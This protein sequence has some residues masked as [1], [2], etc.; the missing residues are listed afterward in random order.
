MIGVWLFA[1]LC[2]C[3][4]AEKAS[5]IPACDDLYWQGEALSSP[6]EAAIFFH[7]YAGTTEELSIMDLPDLASA[8]RLCRVGEGLEIYRVGGRDLAGLG[9]LQTA[10]SLTL[11]G[12]TELET[13]A[14]AGSL[15]VISGTLVLEYLPALASLEGLSGLVAAGGLSV[16]QTG[17]QRLAWTAPTW[18][19]GR[20]DIGENAALEEVELPLLELGYLSVSEQI[21]T[22]VSLPALRTVD[23]VIIDAP[24]L[25]R[26]SAPALTGVGVRLHIAVDNPSGPAA[27]LD[28]PALQ[29]IPMF[30]VCGRISGTLPA[31]G[32]IGTLLQCFLSQDTSLQ[33]TLGLGDLSLPALERIGTIQLQEAEVSGWPEMPAIRAVEHLDLISVSGVPDLRWLAGVEAM[34]V[35]SLV[36][37]DTASLAGLERLAALDALVLYG[38]PD[39]TDAAALSGLAAVGAISIRTCPL[40]ARLELPLISRIDGD[41]TLSGTGLTDLEGFAGLTEIGGDLILTGNPELSAEEV[42]AFLGRVSVGGEVITE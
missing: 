38:L 30:D 21:L 14:G 26:L 31:L 29:S 40:L 32:A 13:L 7:D 41:L 23:T 24:R 25:D 22:D 8:D 11:S 37:T 9:R 19:L 33:G 15:S 35:L 18:G 12:M 20:V 6:E 36:A 34:T 10:G 17:L 4:G 3:G 42:A 28:L 27:A 39:L 5:E 16:R 1:A 2:G